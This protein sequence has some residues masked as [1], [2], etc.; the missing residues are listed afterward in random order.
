M[1][2]PLP[3]IPRHRLDALADG[4]YAIAVTLLVLELKLPPLPEGADDAAL[5]QALLALLPKVMLWLLSFVVA[6]LFWLGSARLGRVAGDPARATTWLELAQLAL[7]SLLPF[8][9]ALMGEHGDRV[10]ASAVYSGHLLALAL[11]AAAKVHRLLGP[12]VAAQRMA[13]LWRAYAV[14]AC[15]AVALALAFVV[16]ARNTYALLPLVLMPLFGRWQRHRAR[17]R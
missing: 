2:E 16:P 15:A 1:S 7:V 9:T 14:A 8:S 5:L 11:V 4:V 3:P 10:A 13:L 6:A 12:E 17:G